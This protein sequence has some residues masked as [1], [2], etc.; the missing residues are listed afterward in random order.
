MKPSILIATGNR[1]K[2][3]EMQ[4]LLK[5]LNVDLVLPDSLG[6]NLQVEENG[7][8]Y[9]ENAGLKAKAYGE[10]S[11][12]LTLADD[13]GLEVDALNG[14][15]GLHSARYNP[16]PNANDRDRRLYLLEKLKNKKEPRNAHFHCTLAIAAPGKEIIFVEGNC[17]GEIIN[18]EKG[19]NGFGYDPIFW[20]PQLQ[21]TMAELTM[22]EKNRVSHRALAVLAALPLIK[23]ILNLDA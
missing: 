12:L 13:S 23:N 4:T 5:P 14:E 2:L 10:V 7:M 9:R 6:L 18:Q 8:T 21:K 15:P 20:L 3:V 11:G 17:P 22:E 16:K 19:D 1:G